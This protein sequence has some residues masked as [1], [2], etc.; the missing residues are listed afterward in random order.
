MEIDFLVQK[1]TEVVP[2]EVK[3]AENLQ[4]KSLRTFVKANEGLNG[5][6]FPLA[7][8]RKQDWMRN[9]PLYAVSTFFRS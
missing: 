5:V 8:Y 6:R 3:A 7:P 2:I 4:S 9:I 1:G